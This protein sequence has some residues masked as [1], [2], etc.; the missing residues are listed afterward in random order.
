MKSLNFLTKTALSI[1][2]PA[3]FLLLLVIGQAGA[4]AFAAAAPSCNKPSI[5]EPNGACVSVAD[6]CGGTAVGKPPQNESVDISFDI[7]CKQEGNP[8]ADATFA[9][10][11]FLSDGVGLVVIG[12]IIYGGIQY[13]ASRGDPQAAAAAIGRIRSSLIALLI[14]VF[15][16]A[17]LNY[18]IPG[19]VLQ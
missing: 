3:F 7:G 15:A 1:F 18:I 14:F 16:Y 4:T 5:L 19:S 11:R 6:T 13:S 8:I 17:I 2:L 12:S 10:I 9:I